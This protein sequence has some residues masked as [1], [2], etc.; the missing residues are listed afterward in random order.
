MKSDLQLLK[1][2]PTPRIYFCVAETLESAAK[3]ENCE[4]FDITNC[5]IAMKCKSLT[6]KT[7]AHTDIML[8]CMFQLE[9]IRTHH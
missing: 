9:R 8:I 2:F 7:S 5:L 3:T 4:K 1:Y 6:N